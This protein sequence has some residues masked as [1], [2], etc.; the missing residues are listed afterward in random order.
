MSTVKRPISDKKLAANRANSKKSTGPKTPRGKAIASQNALEHGL[1]ARD[2]TILGQDYTT[3][4]GIHE[5]LRATWQPANAQEDLLVQRL[6]SLETRLQRC[7]R[8]ETGLLDMEIPDV[9]KDNTRETCNSAA[10]VAFEKRRS[11]SGS[12]IRPSN[13][14]WPSARKS[15]WPLT[16]RSQTMLKRKTARLARKPPSASNSTR[17]WSPPRR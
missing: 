10:G 4:T 8:M 6:A 14:S 12:S 13:S 11:T 1:T 16:K 9:T 17:Q 3:F 7:V 5:Q 2:T 15:S